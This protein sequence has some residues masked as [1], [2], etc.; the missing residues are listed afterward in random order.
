GIAEAATQK[1]LAYAQERR[2]GRAAG[3]PKDGGMSPIV[4]HPDI[5]RT[6]LTMKAQTQM[7]RAITYACAYA[8]DRAR[9][10]EGSE[11]KA[12]QAR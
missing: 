11:A 12:W 7:A 10:G 4:E 1:A 2:Q 6:L 8:I 5:K 3:A 9:L